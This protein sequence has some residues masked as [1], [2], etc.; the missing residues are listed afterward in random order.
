MKVLED[1]AYHLPH[2][3]EP[4]LGNTRSALGTSPALLGTTAF[5][6]SFLVV[7]VTLLGCADLD[8]TSFP[9]LSGLAFHARIDDTGRSEILVATKKVLSSVILYTYG[10][11]MRG[12]LSPMA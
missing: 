12:S 6:R 10:N 4:H 5:R 11:Q 8:T 9:V 3:F 7:M 2:P 1:R